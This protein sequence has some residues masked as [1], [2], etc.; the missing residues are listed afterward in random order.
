MP[1]G[2]LR[3]HLAKPGYFC[4]GDTVEVSPGETATC[5]L[6]AYHRRS[7][8]VRWVYQ[9]DTSTSFLKGDLRGGQAVLSAAGSHRISFKDGFAAV[10]GKSDFFIYQQEGTLLIKNFDVGNPPPGILKTEGASFDQVANAPGGD[11]P[12]EVIPMQPGDVYA[13]KCYDG[14][15]YAKMEVLDVFC[16]DQ[17]GLHSVTPGDTR[18]AVP[19]D[20]TSP[21]E[22][23]SIAVLDFDADDSLSDGTGWVFADRCRNIVLDTGRFIVVDRQNMVDILGEEDFSASVR[24]DDTRCLVNYGRRLRAQKLLSGRVGRIGDSVVLSLELVD[25]STAAVQAV[26]TGQAA[27]EDALLGLLES[28]TCNL[29]RAALSRDP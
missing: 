10:S 15:H 6:R 7:A 23:P 4:S 16:G 9:A 28:V 26:E 11:Y 24:C 1:S 27:D 18:C 2:E 20:P 29:L 14:A 22:Q 13:I 12:R 3:V 25:V 8:L 19:G 21:H 17:R 5:L